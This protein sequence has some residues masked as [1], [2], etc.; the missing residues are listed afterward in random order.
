MP[1][2]GHFGAF[3]AR[4]GVWWRRGKKWRIWG[5]NVMREMHGTNNNNTYQT[6]HATAITQS[7]GFSIFEKTL[8]YLSYIFF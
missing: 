3:M 5:F 8:L 1:L 7:T 6:Q 2:I 4:V